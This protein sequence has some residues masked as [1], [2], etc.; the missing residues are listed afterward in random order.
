LLRRQVARR[1][2]AAVDA[3]AFVG[4][5]LDDAGTGQHL[6]P[7]FGQRLA[8]LLHQ[9]AGDAVGALAQ[10][11]GG[12]AHQGGAFGGRHLAPGLEAALGGGQGAVQVGDGGMGHLADRLAG[13]GVQHVQRLAA[14]GVDPLVVDQQAGVGVACLAHGWAFCRE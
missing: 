1:H 12:L 2:D 7:C 11:A 5:P 14:G 13:G 9:Q 4:E 10:Q 8:L 6:D 3:L